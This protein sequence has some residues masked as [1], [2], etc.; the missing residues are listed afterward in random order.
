MIK[1]QVANTLTTYEANKNN[2][3]EQGRIG[4]NIHGNNNDIPSVC[5]YDEFLNYQPRS[6]YDNEGI[7]G[8]TLYIEKM[9]SIF[10]ISSY[11]ENCLVKIIM[12]S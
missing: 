4:S 8:L 7:I 12:C 2:T 11:A 3:Y 10:H 6:F 1:Q 5:T 9:E